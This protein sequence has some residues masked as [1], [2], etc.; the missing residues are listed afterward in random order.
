[1]TQQF[2]YAAAIETMPIGYR[3]IDANTPIV[4]G[5]TN[6]V[7][8]PSPNGSV[9]LLGNPNSAYSSVSGSWFTDDPM[10]VA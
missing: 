7:A 5:N 10:P 4:S 8:Y 9:T 1:M 2:N 6:F 3:P